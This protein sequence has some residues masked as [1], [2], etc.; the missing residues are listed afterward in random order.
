MTLHLPLWGQAGSYPANLDRQLI[1]A[2]FGDARVVSGMA[3]TQRGL[4]ANMS[5]DIAAGRV[6]MPGPSG[7]YLGYS[8]ATEN[9]TIG[10]APAA[11]TSR[12]DLITAK[13]TDPVAMGSGAALGWDIVVVPGAA[14]ATPTEPAVPAWS[15]LL[16]RVLVASGTVTISSSLV[17]DMRNFG[18]LLA[19]VTR[20]A[21]SS[22]DSATVAIVPV[23]GASRA[24]FT[25][26]EARTVMVGMQA[27]VER[28]VAGGLV[29]VTA[30]V[31]GTE[32]ARIQTRVDVVGGPGQE[33]AGTARPV[34]LSAGYH[35]LTVGL[36]AV[37]N[38]AHAWLKS[39]W[40][41]YVLDVGPVTPWTL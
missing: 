3:V 29:R 40:R 13:M 9:R 22:N 8:D 7:S 19:Q 20:S 18:G 1:S 23:D 32:A 11:G 21:D 33:V 15:T 34:Q 2:M 12:Y 17:V 39:G 35:T 31:D 25:L 6:V 37:T 27:G 41:A 10:A 16:G 30:F 38:G 5:V 26:T 4:G 14:A 28:S 24:F 36:Y